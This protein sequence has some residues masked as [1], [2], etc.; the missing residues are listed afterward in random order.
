MNA[1]IQ[2]MKSKE[3]SFDKP[4][5]IKVDYMIMKTRLQFLNILKKFT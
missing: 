5:S 1:L 2:K 4:I 3:I